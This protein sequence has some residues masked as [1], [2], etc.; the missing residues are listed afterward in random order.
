[1][2]AIF[3]RFSERLQDHFEWRIVLR[4]IV[5][6]LLRCTYHNYIIFL[7][8]TILMYMCKVF[9]SK[10]KQVIGRELLETTFV[11]YKNSNKIERRNPLSVGW[12]NYNR[13]TVYNIQLKMTI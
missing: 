12:R 6:S 7:Y 10:K 2:H 13:L 8:H 9:L 4:A 11:G 1:M 5:L 3:Y